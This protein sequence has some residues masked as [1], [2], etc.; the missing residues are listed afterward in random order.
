MINELEITR[1]VASLLGDIDHDT[2]RA[3]DLVRIA[4]AELTARFPFLADPQGASQQRRAVLAQGIIARAVAR[5]LRNPAAQEGFA[6]ESEGGYSYSLQKL[7]AS[8]NLWFPDSD[9]ALL[10]ESGRTAGVGSSR[11]GVAARS[12]P[13]RY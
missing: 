8:G 11:I 12:L 5:V 6:S 1:L 2:L 4:G 3:R 7:D 13:C 10:R 9:L